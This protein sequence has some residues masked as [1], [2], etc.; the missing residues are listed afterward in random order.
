MSEKL[1]R[2]LP[3]LS[4]NLSR[5]SYDVDLSRYNTLKVGGRAWAM[6]E[7]TCTEDLIK[8]HKFALDNDIPFFVLGLGSNVIPDDRGFKGLVIS[9]RKLN[10][11]P[12][13]VSSSVISVS[14]GFYLPRL[15]IFCQKLG[16]SGLEWAIGIPGTVG[17]G[18]WMNAG[19]S[20]NDISS[21][22]EEITVWD[23]N[24]TM[25][26]SKDDVK[27]GHRYSE[28]QEN[29]NL[30]I[31]GARF[32]LIESSQSQV[33]QAIQERLQVIKRTQPRSYPSVGTV[34]KRVVPRLAAGMRVGGMVCSHENPNWILNMGNGTSDDMLKL[35]K[36]IYWKHL[37]RGLPLP[38]IEPIF[39]PY[40]P[41]VETSHT[42]FFN[43]PPSAIQ[44]LGRIFRL[45]RLLAKVMPE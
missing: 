25:I 40:D 9:T 11:S 2:L 18:I 32:H 45:W 14:C 23:G 35:V 21:V 16:L 42:Q 15:V 4:I 33:K 26:L 31:L 20:G 30:I 13:L 39:M 27:W 29:R 24:K 28:F 19:A 8:I 37:W 34:F 22:L 12:E 7:P 36:R 1:N 17:G 43:N 41:T 3:E 6:A 38:T 5:V 10:T 44:C